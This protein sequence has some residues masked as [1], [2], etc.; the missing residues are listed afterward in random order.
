VTAALRRIL[1]VFTATIMSLTSLPALA[2]GWTKPTPEELQMTVEPA[3]PGA[4]AI[5]LFRDER[6]DDKLHTHTTYARLKILTEKGTENAIQEISYDRRRF[7]VVAV[8]GRTIHSDGT[9]IPFAGKPYEKVLERAGSESYKATVFTLPDVQL[10]SILEYRYV[11]MY[12]DHWVMPPSWYLQGA[13]YV[14][15]AHFQ[16]LANEYNV[17]DEHGNITR[18]QIAYSAFL[19]QGTKIV[20]S[21][22]TSL[23][24]LDVEKIPAYSHEEFMPPMQNITYRALF[25]YSN[26]R[27]AQ[28]F[29]NNEGKYWSKGVDKFIDA[30]KLGPA[31]SQIVGATDTPA[32]KLQK[33]YGAVMRL[34]NTSLTASDDAQEVKVSTAADVWQQKRGNRNEITELFVGLVRAAGMKAYVGVVTNRDRNIF[35]ADYL[36]MGQLNDDIAIVE[37]DGREGRCDPGERYAAYGE[38]HWK[39][40]AT[41]GIRQTEKGAAMFTTPIPGYQSTSIVRNAF[42]ALQPDGTVSGT[43]RISFS[44]SEALD[45]RE[46]ALRNGQ[47]AFKQRFEGQM[48]RQIPPGVVVKTDS[49]LGLTEWDHSLLGVFNVSGAMGTMA[50]K[51]VFLPATFFAATSR[52]PFA[53]E[54][55]TLPIDLHY[56]YSMQDVV[57][58]KLPPKFDIQ[59]LPK[60]TDFAYPQNVYYRAKFTQ[61]AGTVKSVRVFVLGN[62]FYKAEEYPELKG[63]YLKADAKDKEPAVLQLKQTAPAIVSGNPGVGTSQ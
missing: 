41:E 29:W 43:V 6:A 35:A 36:N 55:R 59:S 37:L 28:D 51:L 54:K 26:V 56:T 25:Y 60:D 8:E 12:D 31:L 15:K 48:Q 61:E 47:E 19:P 23:Y 33:I 40:T 5:Y 58:I 24:T 17:K 57:T 4:A 20:Y 34:E 44:G 27:N 9:A 50:A 39:H 11:L 3:A 32:Q 49:V 30:G 13:L 53:L 45:W 16:F 52:P 63:F 10:G 18:N 46:F 2:D 1:P 62:V 14:R 42:L 22:A 38:L 7:K 21:P